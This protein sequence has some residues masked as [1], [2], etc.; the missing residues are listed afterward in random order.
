[1]AVSKAV[2]DGFVDDAWC[3]QNCAL[4]PPHCPIDRCYCS[5]DM[6]IIIGKRWKK[7]SS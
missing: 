4:E 6:A 2:A 5:D 1:M 3:Q 7:P